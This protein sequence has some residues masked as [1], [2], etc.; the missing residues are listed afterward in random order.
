MSVGKLGGCPAD[1]A[2]GEVGGAAECRDEAA[3]LLRVGRPR[4]LEDHRLR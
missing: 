2:L 4:R 3:P 1:L